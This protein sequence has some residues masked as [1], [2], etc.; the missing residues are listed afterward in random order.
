M[1]NT[2]TDVS[3][4]VRFELG[5]VVMTPGVAD[6][7]EAGA[8]TSAALLGRHARGDWGDG[9]IEDKR[10]N[11]AAILSGDRL[12]SAYDVTPG[13]RVWI[14]TEGEDDDGHRQAT[15]LLLPDE[16]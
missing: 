11:D 3:R 1:D 13:L 15:T 14:I 4:P 16:Y 12:L 6:L 2:T 8:L 7:M 10:A 5:Q 9:D